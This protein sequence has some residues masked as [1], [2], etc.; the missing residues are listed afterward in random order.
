MIHL[1][2]SALVRA[3]ATNDTFR[4]HTFEVLGDGTTVYAESFRH[5][6]GGDLW[7]LCDERQNGFAS[8]L[9]TFPVHFR[10]FLSTS[11]TVLPSMAV[12]WVIT[13]VQLLVQLFCSFK[14]SPF[15]SVSKLSWSRPFVRS[16]QNLFVSIG[17]MVSISIAFHPFCL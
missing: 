14:Q 1:P 6:H 2:V 9:S 4:L 17:Q 10:I 3:Y 5:L 8:F 11:V 12:E 13:L 7:I 16:P 15:P